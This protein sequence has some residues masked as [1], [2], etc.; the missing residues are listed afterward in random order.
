MARMGG[1]KN[2]LVVILLVVAML[3]SN[4]TSK[5]KDTTKMVTVYTE[6]E[7]QGIELSV[8]RELPEANITERKA[9]FERNG[10]KW[11]H[12]YDGGVELRTWVMPDIS[13]KA[14][15]KAQSNFL[16]AL[17]HLKRENDNRG[18]PYFVKE[19]GKL[20]FQMEGW[21]SNRPTSFVYE[22]EGKL[23]RGV[24]KGK[25]VFKQV[26]IDNKPF[27]VPNEVISM[28]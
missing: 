5:K 24:T 6:M 12:V 7:A 9:D 27:I 18:L 14:D 15:S 11:G 19:G 2:Y 25:G 22:T 20:T 3:A 13:N 1:L 10:E 28:I 4:V 26:D 8:C 23:Y 21:D 17:T 16:K